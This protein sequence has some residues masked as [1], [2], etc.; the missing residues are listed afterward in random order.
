MLTIA[1]QTALLFINAASIVILLWILVLVHRQ[2]AKFHQLK[3]DMELLTK[4]REEEKK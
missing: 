2:N 3:K 1:E 4:A